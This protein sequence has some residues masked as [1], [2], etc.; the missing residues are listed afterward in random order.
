MDGDG[1]SA[2]GFAHSFGGPAGWGAELDFFVQVLKAVYD[3]AY[4]GGLGISFLF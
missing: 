4:N 1:V 2:G 3:K